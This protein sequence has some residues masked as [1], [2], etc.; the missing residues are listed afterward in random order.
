MVDPPPQF[1]FETECYEVGFGEV[2]V[3]TRGFGQCHSFVPFRDIVVSI[4]SSFGTS[5]VRKVI[6]GSLPK[7]VSTWTLLDRFSHL[8]NNFAKTDPV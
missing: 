7:P 1:C 4:S 2:V 8:R 5:N 3:V 6:D